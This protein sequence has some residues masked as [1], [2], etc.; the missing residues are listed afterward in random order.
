[1]IKG[2]YKNQVP[3]TYNIPKPF[4]KHFTEEDLFK[5]D[6]QTFGSLIGPLTNHGTSIIALISEYRQR[7]NDE[8]TEEDKRKL[9]LLE[10]RLKMVCASQSRQI[11]KAKI[12]KEVKAIPKIWK[13]YQKINEDDSEDIKKEKEFYNSILSDRKPYFFKYLYTQEKKRLSEYNKAFDQKLY[14]ITGIH[15]KD[16]LQ[17]KNPNSYQKHLIDNYYK[18]NGFINSNCEMNRICKYIESIDFDIK[19]NIR[20][21]SQF[22]YTLL[23]S[24]TKIW[25]EETYN[26]VKIAMENFMRFLYI[27]YKKDNN[28]Y[29]QIKE[30]SYEDDVFSKRIAFAQFF[31][32]ELLTKY[33]SNER[34]LTNYLLKIFYEDKKSWNKNMLWLVCGNTIYENCL[35]RAN[36]KVRVPIKAKDGC[37]RFWGDRFGTKV[38]DLAG[39]IHD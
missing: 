25:N 14:R 24:P 38:I 27:D 8:G 28:D 6:C 17:L 26:K 3:V 21:N 18:Y 33:C 15:L 1:M 22:D 32:L 4:K 29:K 30:T 35:N 36:Y 5:A 9:E 19:Q 23:M 7:V 16:L 20:D 10:N 39:E 13:T 11:D 31:K 2:V 34:E 12:G 37:I